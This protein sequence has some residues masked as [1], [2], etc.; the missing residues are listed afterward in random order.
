MDLPGTS[1]NRPERPGF[2][3]FENA[4]SPGLTANRVYQNT[5]TNGNAQAQYGDR[6]MYGDSHV[7]HYRETI[8]TSLLGRS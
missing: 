8:H 5:L 4:G 3:P 6:I 1:H 2:F 7:H